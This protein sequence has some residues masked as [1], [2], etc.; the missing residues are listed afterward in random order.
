LLI[1]AFAAAA[2][3]LAANLLTHKN[4]MIIR[5]CEVAVKNRL[6]KILNIWAVL[7]LPSIFNK[8][9]QY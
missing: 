7:L 5:G 3:D 8:P 9:S 1:L 6:S 2:T 4:C